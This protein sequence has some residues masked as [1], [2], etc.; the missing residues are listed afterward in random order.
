MNKKLVFLAMLVSLL[1]LSLVFVSCD[2]GTTS[3]GEYHLKWGTTYTSYSEV[4]GYIISENW[5]VADSGSDWA[6]GTDDTATTVYN[7]CMNHISWAEGGE[8]DGSFEECIDFSKGGVSAP[9][10]L[11]TAGNDNQDK[12]P[13]AGIFDGGFV[14]VLFYITKN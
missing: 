4:Q 7:W 8:V 11:K 12:V 5:D 13:L 6:L 10:G 14:A 9:L 2:N 3:K 1:A